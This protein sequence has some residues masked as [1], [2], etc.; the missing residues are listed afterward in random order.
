[1]AFKCSH[2]PPR[3]PNN[4]GVSGWLPATR[5]VAAIIDFSLVS[6]RMSARY[7]PGSNPS[8]SI[9]S[10]CSGSSWHLIS[11]LFPPEAKD[12]LCL[13]CDLLRSLSCSADPGALMSTCCFRRKRVKSCL[14]V[15]HVCDCS[16]FLVVRTWMTRGEKKASP[17]VLP[18]A[19]PSKKTMIIII[20]LQVQHTNDRKK[21]RE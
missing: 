3:E 2:I 10:F 17:L 8:C 7:Q 4:T 16:L 14:E 11:F 12:F 9:K 20:P 19:I 6:S 18:D 15:W 1:M 13:L 21:E 5:P